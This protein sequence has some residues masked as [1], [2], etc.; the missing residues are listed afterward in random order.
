MG[1]CRLQTQVFDSIC[2]K[3]TTQA[4]KVN[5]FLLSS[6]HWLGTFASHA[7]SYAHFEVMP[8]IALLGTFD[9]RLHC[10]VVVISLT[11]SS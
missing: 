2:V 9:L 4:L 3:D 11:S 7:R 5:C 1:G 8:P 10:H 6:K